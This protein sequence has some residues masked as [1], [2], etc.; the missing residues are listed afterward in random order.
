MPQQVPF[1]Y[2]VSPNAKVQWLVACRLVGCDPRHLMISPA[3]LPPVAKEAPQKAN[4]NIHEAAGHPRVLDSNYSAQSSIPR[5]RDATASLRSRAEWHPSLSSH[6]GM[7]D[8]P[9]FPTLESVAET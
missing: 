7:S 1:V 4:K 9:D 5:A 6:G 3:S 8:Y 2:A